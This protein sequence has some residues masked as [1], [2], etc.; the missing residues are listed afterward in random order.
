MQVYLVYLGVLL[1]LLLLINRPVWA[2]VGEVARLR[3]QILHQLGL[4]NTHAGRAMARQRI[5]ALIPCQGAYGVEL[6]G[7]LARLAGKKRFWLCFL[8]DQLLVVSGFTSTT[9]TVPI[10][11]VQRLYL[12]HTR[13]VDSGHLIVLGLDDD[14]STLLI[15]DLVDIVRLVNLLIQQGVRLKTY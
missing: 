15:R 14:N 2:A 13:T 12:P 10:Q 11:G 8:P 9:V 1:L 6:A 3:L 7:R 5:L 4:P